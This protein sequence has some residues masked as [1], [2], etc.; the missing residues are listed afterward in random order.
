M[1][2]EHRAYKLIFRDA[3]GNESPPPARPGYQT[4]PE[5]PS[6]IPGSRI[7]LPFGECPGEGFRAEGY[8]FVV[9]ET[10]EGGQTLVLEQLG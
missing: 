6:I 7:N 10:R 2:E 1:H 8:W 4:P 3:H 5:Y 9:V